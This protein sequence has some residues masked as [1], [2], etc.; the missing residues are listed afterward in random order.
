[1]DIVARDAVQRSALSESIADWADS[2]IAALAAECKLVGIVVDTVDDQIDK[3]QI[4]TY[5]NRMITLGAEPM[6]A[7]CCI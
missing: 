4:L 7:A 5:S 3:N 2:W 6:S 1:M